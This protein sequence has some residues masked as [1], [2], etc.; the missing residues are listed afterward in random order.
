[1]PRAPRSASLGRGRR[2]AS[3]SSLCSWPPSLP[4]RPVASTHSASSPAG[5]RSPTS[6]YP[7]AS[8][9]P[10]L[11]AERLSSASPAGCVMRPAPLPLRLACRLHVAAVLRQPD[12]SGR[13]GRPPRH[14]VC[15]LP[16]RERVRRRGARKLCWKVETMMPVSVSPADVQCAVQQQGHV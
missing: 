16:V 8:Q 5:A 13:R 12:V 10:R 11:L 14:G 7:L 9:S 4:P 2:R 15:A 6:T 1:M 3:S